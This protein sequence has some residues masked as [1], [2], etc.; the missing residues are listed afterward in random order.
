MASVLFFHMQSE[1]THK[2]MQVVP[3]TI[4]IAFNW[5]CIL[6]TLVVYPSLAIYVVFADRKSL[7]KGHFKKRAGILIRNLKLGTSS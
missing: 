5:F 1:Q 2:S 4:T 3:Y 6:A 7:K